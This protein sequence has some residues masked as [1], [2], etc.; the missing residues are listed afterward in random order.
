MY[1]N[2]APRSARSR[3]AAAAGRPTTVARVS[4]NPDLSA[5]EFAA[6]KGVSVRTVRNWIA[7]GYVRAIRVGPRLV[8]IPATELERISTPI[9]VA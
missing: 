5:A 8:R 7:A 2:D 9:E 4:V 6:A 1:N 3:S